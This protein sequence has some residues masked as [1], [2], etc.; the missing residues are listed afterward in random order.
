MRTLKKDI[1]KK[2]KIKVT[3][4]LPDEKKNGGK[5]VT[6]EGILKKIDEIN[7]NLILDSNVVISI[8]EIID[9]IIVHEEMNLL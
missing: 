6:I 4:F 1:D 2:Y 7:K 9:V 5:Y 8:D 3:Y